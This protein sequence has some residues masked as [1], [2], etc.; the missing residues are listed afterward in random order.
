M[1]KTYEYRGYKFEITKSRTAVIISSLSG[2]AHP[3]G[4]KCDGRFC[5]GRDWI[6]FFEKFS[7][8]NDGPKKQ[9]AEWPRLTRRL[10]E[11]VKQQVDAHLKY[12]TP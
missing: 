2:P 11:Q 10:R 9:K 5:R 7:S 4:S 1:S 8:I 12:A 6:V 3:K